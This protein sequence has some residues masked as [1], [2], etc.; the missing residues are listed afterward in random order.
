MKAFI[1]GST[2]ITGH[3]PA[4]GIGVAVDGDTIVQV[5]PDAEIAALVSDPHDIVD[6]AG[7]LLSPGFVDSHLHPA[8][9]GL[10]LG[11]CNLVPASGREE[12]LAIIRDYVAAHPE[13]EWIVGGGWQMS[14]FPGGTPT[15]ELLDEIC[16]DRPVSL[17]NADHHGT[18]VNSLALQ[19]A[20]ITAET[21]DPID[22]R[23][24]RDEEGNA[25]GTL[26]EGA[27]YLV[28]ELRP[29]YSFEELYAAL[30]RAQQHCFELGITGWQDAAVVDRDGVDHLDVYRQAIESGDLK[31]RVSGALWYERE[32]GEPQVDDLIARRATVVADPAVFDAGTVKI[33][34]DGIAENFTAAMSKPYL[35]ACG[36]ETGNSGLSFVD[37]EA[38]KRVV[39]RLDASGA[40]LHFHALGDRAV[41]EALDA[42]QVAVEA[43]G[44]GDNRHSLA[45]LQIVQSRDVE[46]FAEVSAV[47][48]IQPYWARNEAQMTELTLPFL[49]PDLAA[50]Q[51]PFHDFVERGVR[52]AGGS[53]WPVSSANPLAGMQVAVTRIAEIAEE[54][55]EPFIPEQAISLVDAWDAY[56]IGS[57][58][59]NHRDHLTGS[60]EV[61]KLADLV[62]L[63][64]DPFSTEPRSITKSRVVSTWI[65]GEQVY[66][67]ATA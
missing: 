32:R 39:S 34:V 54:A 31:A 46:R 60:I 13:D 1:G 29:A 8:M 66:P 38:L 23:I 6:L 11:Q 14:W 45:H 48:N 25:A 5:G 37:P 36:H 44:E 51:Y 61:G 3:G 35:D 53:D 58:Y 9:G 55:K 47:A 41:T 42:L 17:A 67:L 64:S 57:S 62:V 22:G 7:G 2:Y 27:A 15:R 40:Q 18:W 59:L 20:G 10:E 43:N 56:T 33:M 28:D 50:R 65:G 26:H 52:L 63:S 24:E 30:L 21:P 4:I 49:D 16:P 12:C 19:L